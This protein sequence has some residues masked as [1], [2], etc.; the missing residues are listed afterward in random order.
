MKTK[1]LFLLTIIV[2]TAFMSCIKRKKGCTDANASNYCSGCNEGNRSCTYTG[3]VLF[4]WDKTTRDSMQAHLLDSIYINLEVPYSATGGGSIFSS[5]NN[6][7]TVLGPVSTSGYWTQAPSWGDFGTLSGKA[8]LKH[9]KKYN[10]G[11]SC[12]GYV[13][14][15]FYNNNIPFCTTAD[16]VCGLDYLAGKV[17]VIK[18]IWK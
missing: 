15:N 10:V 17:V 13:G 12:A 11:Y 1:L 8:S 2:L 3:K 7:W 14:P 4:W 9:S 16:G 5:P 18:L 6:Q